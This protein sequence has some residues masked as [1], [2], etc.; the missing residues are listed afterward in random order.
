MPT[1]NNELS[2][3]STVCRSENNLAAEIDDE[4]VLMSVEK[5][6]YYGLDAIGADIWRR[7]DKP[8]LVSDLCTALGNEYDADA[9]TIRRDVLAL[10]ERLAAEGMIEIKP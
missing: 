7:L 10:L 8:V 3:A 4:L 9:D 5:A 6:S 2:L 1:R